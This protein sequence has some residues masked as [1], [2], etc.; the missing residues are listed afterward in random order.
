MNRIGI[1][2]SGGDAPGMNAALRSAVRVALDEGIEI[3]A[4]YEGYQGMVAGG[5]QIRPL[6]WEDVGGILHGGGTKIGTARCPEFRKREGRRQAAKNLLSYGIDALVVIGGD[7]SLTG[8]HIFRQEWPELLDELVEAGEIDGRD[9][10]NHPLLKIVG[11]PGSIDN[12]MLGTDMT[13]GADTALHRITEAI[14]AITSTA[15]SHQRSFVVEVMGRNCGYLAMMGALSAGADWVFI[16]EQPPDPDQ[17]R[18]EMC[19]ELHEG[20]QAGRRDSIVVLAE[21]ACDS[22]GT[23]ITSQDVKQT[24]EEQIGEETRITILGHVQRG[25]SP[26]AFDRN[27]GSILGHAAV[28]HLLES[29]PEDEPQLI[30]M[31]GNRVNSISMMES[32]EMTQNIKSLAEEKKF[33]QVMQLRG[34][35]F[36]AT[37]NILRTLFQAGPRPEKEAD[38]AYRIAVMHAG[39]PAPGMNTAVRAAVRWGRNQGHTMLGVYNGFPGL[40]KGEVEELGWMDVSGWVHMGGAEIGTNRVRPSNGDFY[41]IARAV[42]QKSIDALLVIGGETGYDGVYEMVSRRREF[43]TLNLP[44]VCLP[45]TIDNDR[46]GSEL[47]IGADTAL[48]SIVQAVDQIK[49]SAVASRRS[50]VVETMGGYCGYLTLM[51]GMATGAERVY[52]HEEG[53]SL[54]DLQRDVDHLVTGFKRGKRLGLLIRNEYAHPVYTTD[55]MVRLFEVEGED[56]FD[57]RQAILGHQQQGGNPTPFDRIQA[58]R[59]GVRSVDF[60]LQEIP[61]KEPRAAF[62]GMK[63]GKI[64]FTGMEDYKRLEDWEYGR[65]KTQWWMDLRPIARVL[66]Q[67]GPGN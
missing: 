64:T 23:P 5:D 67:P 46:P 25:G 7:G 57:V 65:P 17:W 54:Q 63:G 21:G 15:S 6:R 20:R 16:P 62:I 58:T 61:E 4:I 49:Q 48:N 13:I 52:I 41:S 47:S 30:G 2:T 29:S 14:D 55:F 33:G 51:G 22:E 18:D 43:P 12:D 28:H 19:R 32:V 31:R 24:L 60:L 50:F 8:A 3:Y 1:F 27:L 66:A 37:Y 44:I 34:E 10:D 45:A 39:G 42:E 56:L 11:L 59:L 53:I 9:A 35:S 26:S 36:G 40:M 38:P